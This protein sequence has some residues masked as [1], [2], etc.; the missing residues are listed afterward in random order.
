M[1]ARV[2]IIITLVVGAL[3]AGCSH[4][5]SDTPAQSYV[6]TAPTSAFQLS[7]Q[8]L[9]LSSS[10]LAD[11]ITAQGDTVGITYTARAASSCATPAGAIAIAG[12][13]QPQIDVAGAPLLFLA[14]AVGSPPAAC[15]VTVT[16]SNGDEATTDVTY[17]TIVLQTQ[18]QTRRFAAPLD[19]SVAPASAVI[20]GIDRV[21]PL[22]ASGFTGT[23]S[24]S[25]GAC[26]TGSSGLTI[27]PASVP[28]GAGTFYVAP[29]GQGAVSKSCT[30][31][32]SDASGKT[33]TVAVTLSIGALAKF[34]AT[35]HAVQFGCAGSSPMPC[36]TLQSVALSEPGAQSLSIVTRPSLKDSCA[37]AF[38]G[39]L[40]MLAGDGTLT[41]SVS[42]PSADVAFQGLLSAP[43]LGCAKIVLTDNGDPAQRVTL[44]VNPAIAAAPSGLSAA[45]A[46][47]CVGPDPN[48]A[49]PNAPHGAYVWNP[50]VVDGG[51]YETQLEQYVIGKDPTLCGV[52]LVVDWS[53][54]E[55]QKGTFDWSDIDTLAKPYTDAGLRVNLLF[56]AGPERGPKN[57]VTPAWVTAST[58]DGG[59][60]VPIVQ[61]DNQPP[62]PD[63]IDP[64]FES[65]WY[66]FIAAA[67]KHFSYDNS[68][69]APSIGYMRFAIGFG[70]EAIPAHFDN[71]EHADCLAKWEADPVDVTYDKWVAHAKGVVNAMGRQ[72]TDKQLMI[73]L[74]ELD[75]G[76]SIYDYPNAV[77][78]DA[79]NKGIGFGT[80][81]LGI[82]NVA[83]A[84][85]VPHA[86]N[87]TLEIV[88]L[89][90]C[91]AFTRHVGV[92]PYEFQTIVASTAP[93]PGV[94][95][96]VLGN[97]LQYGM[98]NNAQ[99]FELYPQEW[100]AADVSGFTT[101]SD[102]AAH[103]AALH[104]ASLVLGAASPAAP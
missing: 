13:G 60:G 71:G 37:N 100:M 36:R 21:L 82:A 67:V 92:V 93:Q 72:T 85:A 87:P 26:G 80:E 52:S 17:Q 14:Y 68:S 96:I 50:Y 81:N 99:I 58:A 45:V 9:E 3:L 25:A 86:C 55:P 34:V 8:P 46:P 91:Q 24:A 11:A 53:V 102:Q 20:A 88:N 12:D 29:F 63:Y 59:D 28:N 89:Y 79:A 69:I 32:L 104:E 97:A 31:T 56:A 84:G 47:P 10:V 48:V 74:N 44:T 49:A 38:V 90:W 41:Q 83:I 101:A 98:D 2:R 76:P 6:P 33:A 4:S 15:V 43:S 51:E 22:A 65:D 40:K 54:L 70:V 103:A 94:S 61:C 39:P 95:S 66:A 7:P 5:G 1:T 42:G 75:G 64:T 35:P 18:A 73:A 23:V 16:G 77:T 78:E 57:P 27:R 62:A 19:V 30:V